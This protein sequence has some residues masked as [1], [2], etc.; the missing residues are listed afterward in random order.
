MFKLFNPKYFIYGLMLG[1][2][3][4][5]PGLSGGSVAFVL[6]IYE[7]LI[8]ALANLKP[9][10]IVPLLK[11]RAWKNILTDLDGAFLGLL[12]A[13]KV[14]GIFIFS[15]FIPYLVEHY[16]HHMNALFFGLMVASIPHIFRSFKNPP[17]HHHWLI[18]VAVMAATVFLTTLKGEISLSGSLFQ[19]VSGALAIIAMLLPGISGSFVLVLLGNYQYI[20]TQINR[21][22]FLDINAALNLIPFGIGALVG[23]V[24]FITII[25][26]CLTFF[27]RATLAVLTGLMVGSLPALWPFANQDNSVIALPHSFGLHE[28]IIVTLFVIGIIITTTSLKVIDK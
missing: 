26:Y 25:K 1:A 18:M 5:M 6:G 16:P 22:F 8:N 19:F 13:G 21:L 10:L 24:I 4:T 28:T 23:V 27:H 11:K 20:F 9:K 3:G 14:G 7:R 15:L 12:L 2:A 17:R